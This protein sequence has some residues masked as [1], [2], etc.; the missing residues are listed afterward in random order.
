[1]S[2]TIDPILTRADR[3]VGQV[4]GKVGKLLDAFA[5]IEVYLFID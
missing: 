1:M 2:T 4:L 3:I 5:E